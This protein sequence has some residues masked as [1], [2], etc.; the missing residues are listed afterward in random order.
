MLSLHTSSYWLLLVPSGVRG[1]LSQE[2]G[3]SSYRSVVS[4]SPNYR[5]DLRHG[6]GGRSRL[7]QE[8]C[9]PGASDPPCESQGGWL[10]LEFGESF[11]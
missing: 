2:Q 6:W 5:G 3:G 9:F 11:A 10:S 1:R 4:L 8:G 7:R